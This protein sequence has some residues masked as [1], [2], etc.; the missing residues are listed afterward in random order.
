MTVNYLGVIDMKL[1][2]SFMKPKSRLPVLHVLDVSQQ[3]DYQV[4]LL[5]TWHKDARLAWNALDAILRRYA[6]QYFVHHGPC[7]YSPEASVDISNGVSLWSGFYQNICASDKTLMLNMDFSASAFFRGGPLLTLASALLGKPL[8]D[9]LSEKDIK[10]LNELLVGY[11]V[12]VLHRGQ[13]DRKFKIKQI[14]KSASAIFF[15]SN[16]DGEKQSVADYFAI[17]YQ[18]LQYPHLPCILTGSSKRPVYFPLEVCDFLD[19]QRHRHKLSERQT[20]EMIRFTC[21]HPVTRSEKILTGM[22]LTQENNQDYLE[23]F[24]ISV[25][26]QDTIIKAKLLDPP[27]LNFHPECAEPSVQ[28]SSGV[29]N[30]KNKLLAHGSDLLSWS[31]VIFG[32]QKEYP[33]DQVTSFV[34]KL[35]Q[36]FEEGGMLVKTK[37]PPITYA[38]PRQVE[39]TMIDTYLMTGNTFEQRPQMILCV[40]PNSGAHL[41]AQVKSSCETVI[42][43]MSQCLLA[44]H[45]KAP[46]KQYFANLMLKINAK[47]GGINAYSKGLPFVSDKPTLV[48]GA[49]M[50]H[51]TSEGGCSLG[52]LVANMDPQC[53][54]YSAV[55]T[56]QKAG[57][58]L[59][60]LCDMTLEVL[61]RFYQTNGLKPE[62]ILY[63]RTYPTDQHSQNVFDL[64]VKALKK[65]FEM[66]ESGYQPKLT[67]VYVQKRHHAKFFPSHPKDMDKTGNILP[68]TV[69]DTTITAPH[70]QEFYLCAHAGLQGTSKTT[71]YQI[72]LNES[73]SILSKE[74]LEELSYR[75]CFLC[76][77]ATRSISL[78]PPLYYAHL[79]ATR[80]RFHLS[81]SKLSMVKQDIENLM[82]F[83]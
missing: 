60:S 36:V 80:A 31:I 44:K 30:M 33:V 38:H 67:F 52:A 49:D 55:V 9:R 63:F 28:V 79:V 19:G 72:M 23:A 81:G 10:V 56:S 40:L 18:P 4:N 78:V 20:I 17:K 15:D 70:D 54:T 12:V 58:A 32:T 50:T 14:T 61:K 65:A 51:P 74:K 43:V 35:V 45:I 37:E 13:V 57:R 5:D 68:G 39:K 48:L 7:F 25:N 6:L 46:K 53:V 75:L 59:Y 73:E 34:G 21:Q 41:Y 64:E 71:R 77:R 11:F 2:N 26:Q 1:L 29:W 24:G 8:S 27:C 22:T 76:C 16:L 42:G 83:V 62:R 47:L 69:I 66:I 3:D 82:Y